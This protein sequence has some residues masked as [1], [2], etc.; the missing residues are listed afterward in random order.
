MKPTI[1]P[2]VRTVE[3]LNTVVEQAERSGGIVLHTLVDAH[4]RAAMIAAA[5]RHGVVEVDA[6]GPVLVA[7]AFAI[8]GVA[9]ML[10]GVALLASAVPARQASLPQ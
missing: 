9:L 4:L 6:M 2:R 5:R 1:V 8:G 7:A 3:D 10:V